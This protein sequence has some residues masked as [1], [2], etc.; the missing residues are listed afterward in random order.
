MM[1]ELYV[2]KCGKGYVRFN[3]DGTMIACR[4]S[5]AITPAKH[6]RKLPFNVALAEASGIIKVEEVKNNIFQRN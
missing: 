6:L 5:N 3:L 1:E 4:Y 2:I